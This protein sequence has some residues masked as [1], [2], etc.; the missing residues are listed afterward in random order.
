MNPNNNTIK[1]ALSIEDTNVNFYNFKK[2]TIR[3]ITSKVFEANVVANY[4]KCPQCGFEKLVHNGHFVSL[5]TY[6]SANASIPVYLELHKERL[7][8]RNCHSTVMAQT[9]LV[10]KFCNIAKQTKQKLVMYLQ[11][12]RTQECIARDINVSPNT[13]TRV[14]DESDDIFR[15]NYDFLPVHLS[16]DEFRGIKGQLHFICINGDGD[17]EIVQILPDRFKNHII[18]YFRKFPQSVRDRVKTVSIDLN[19]Y[20][21]DIA[22]QMF[23]NAEIIVDRFHIVSMMTRSFNQTRTHLMKQYDKDSKEYRILKFAWKLYLMHV[24]ELDD[25]QLFYDRHLRQ[26]VT[27]LT[28]VSQGLDLDETLKSTYGAMQGIMISLKNH[29]KQGILYYLNDNSQLSPQMKD[30]LTTF[31]KNLEF[32]LNAA[33]TK[34]S[35]G[36]IEGINRMI[37]QIQRTAFGFRNYHHL[38]TRIKLNQARTKKRVIS[39]A[40]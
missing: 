9:D 24:D 6:I 27:A 7:L 19:S 32:I 34:Y 13:V 37:K 25:K 8:C 1:F 11:D 30:T 12:D 2:S 36:P 16:M 10:D 26:Q 20:Y 21:K 14:L 5:V 3:G 22:K 39:R 40:A 35:N 38:I 23:P 4:S 29:D 18:E 15:R 31:K 28:R 33:E 17:H